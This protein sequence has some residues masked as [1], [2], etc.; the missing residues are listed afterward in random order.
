MS[1]TTSQTSNLFIANINCRHSSTQLQ[2]SQ[3][4]I[5]TTS[6][7]TMSSLSNDALDNIDTPLTTRL[8]R[9]NTRLKDIFVLLT[10]MRAVLPYVNASEREML[11]YSIDSANTLHDTARSELED[12][13]NRAELLIKYEYAKPN[14]V[15]TDNRARDAIEEALKMLTKVMDTLGSQAAEL[16]G[17]RVELLTRWGVEHDS[18]E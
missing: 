3:A 9:Y 12:V 15:L 8:L 7:V 14:R 6:P 17:V 11:Q 10:T 4:H 13:Y 18:V 1:H 2:I 16:E 5:D